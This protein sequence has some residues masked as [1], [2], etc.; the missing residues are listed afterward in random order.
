M[1][2]FKT[3]ERERALRARDIRSIL[4]GIIIMT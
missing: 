4:E 3:L 2:L 1:V